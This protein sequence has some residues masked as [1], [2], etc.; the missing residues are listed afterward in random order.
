MD[1]PIGRVKLPH[2]AAFVNGTEA[3]NNKQLQQGFAVG[4]KL[5]LTYRSDPDHELELSCFAV[6]NL[7]A[8]RTLGPENPLNWYVMK[9]PGS[10]PAFWQTQDFPYQGMTWSATSRV[11][12]AEVNARMRS[13]NRPNLLVG[14]RWLQ[15]HDDLV[16][17][18]TPSDRNEPAWKTS[19]AP[20]GSNPTLVEIADCAGAA[21]A[22]V[23]GWRCR[24]RGRLPRK[25]SL[26]TPDPMLVR[27]GWLP[28][29]LA[30]FGA[31]ASVG[32][33][34]LQWT[35]AHMQRDLE[36]AD[37]VRERWDAVRVEIRRAEDLQDNVAAFF[38][39]TGD[40][41]G[42]QFDW[43]AASLAPVQFQA[44]SFAPHVPALRRM[45]FERDQGREF[46]Q[47]VG[48][49]E[50]QSDGQPT[51]ALRRDAYF[52][53]SYIYPKNE[54]LAAL[55]FDLLS[56]PRRQQALMTAVQTG[57]TVRTDPI[58]LVQRPSDWAFLVFKAV[59]AHH[60][61][62]ASNDGSH[63]AVVGVVSSVYTF[64]SL[65]EKAMKPDEGMP[66]G[67]ALFDTSAPALPIFV[68]HASRAGEHADLHRPQ[69]W[70]EALPGARSVKVMAMQKELTAVFIAEGGATSVWREINATILATLVIGLLLT[71]GLVHSHIWISRLVG[72]LRATAAEARARK[73]EA[74]RAAAEKSRL[75]T[76][77]SHDLRQ[78][79]HALELFV[80]HLR[81]QPLR[82]ETAKI[83]ANIDQSV[84]ALGEMLDAVLDLSRLERG[85][86]QPVIGP[87]PVRELWE[88][89]GD[90]FGGVAAAKNLS[91]HFRPSPLWLM[92]DPQLLHRIM[93]NL[94]SNAIRYTRTGGVLVACRRSGA[95]ASLEVWDTGIGIPT[96]HQA[97]IFSAFVQLDNPE[98]QRVNG[99]GV[100]LSIVDRAAAL[101]NI[102]LQ[103]RS[104]PGRGSCFKVEVPI[105]DP[106]A[107][108]I[109]AA[110][111]SHASD[112]GDFVGRTVLVVE[113]EALARRAL[114]DLL[115]SWGCAVVEAASD[116][117]A[118]MAV[119]GGCSPDLMIS[120]FGLPDG[121]NGV[122]LVAWTRTRLGREVAAA[123]ISGDTS[124][125]VAAG[126]ERAGL[127]LLHKPVQAARLRRLMLLLLGRRR[128]MPV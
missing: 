124:P 43:F 105:T 2:W 26:K 67:V 125:E 59:Y 19:A 94:V 57:K 103:L 121:R 88:R 78:P 47:A 52:P 114:T 36:F 65:V 9:A 64:R 85:A 119:S 77:A 86:I 72:R 111:G 79:L 128:E 37:A 6:R 58:R 54:N 81:E 18:L 93:L 33:A 49:W 22:P 70:I 87:M 76:Y 75:L 14:L 20:C 38:E 63:P 73:D 3:L 68:H 80:A 100:G 12:G 16:G 46:G 5:T 110:E 24:A 25:R 34:W 51:P 127:W 8:A 13:A 4:P 97:E 53:V 84:Q 29:A 21:G 96:E 35:I 91:L 104:V 15:L 50:A 55:G 118:R 30:L 101:L 117:E 113:D 7:S 71:G 69:A 74:E 98:R 82:Y 115:R 44:V 102:R 122:E 123:I 120:D 95:H 90:E 28:I 99:L 109:R 27:P 1:G 61:R 83:V 10:F 31:I 41:T 89:L 48:I 92:T 66:L 108:P 42:A 106:V 56:E 60:Q 39:A 11:Q 112:R 126:T 32:L 62:A 17:S 23:S 107:V 40:V 116:D 45:E